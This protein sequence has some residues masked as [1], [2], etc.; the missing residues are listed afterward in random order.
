MD[1]RLPY[2]ALGLLVEEDHQVRV[3]IRLQRLLRELVRPGERVRGAAEETESIRTVGQA[4]MPAR[5]GHGL[6]QQ[7][8]VGAAGPA[9]WTVRLEHVGVRA[10]PHLRMGD[11]G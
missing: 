1:E 9:A 4:D 6:E 8:L 5:L 10:E 3:E 2:F 7:G 11:I